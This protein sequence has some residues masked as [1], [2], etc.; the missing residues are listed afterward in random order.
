LK[1]LGSNGIQSR[2]NVDLL[3]LYVLMPDPRPVSLL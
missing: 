1:W 2:D 3:G